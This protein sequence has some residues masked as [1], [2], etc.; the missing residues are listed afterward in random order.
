MINSCHTGVC[1]R[2]RVKFYVS[3]MVVKN[4]VTSLQYLCLCSLENIVCQFSLRTSKLIIKLV[5]DVTEHDDDILENTKE[6][7]CWNHLFDFNN[8]KT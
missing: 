4:D 6:V 3:A 2:T 1:K 5:P 8:Y 7:Y